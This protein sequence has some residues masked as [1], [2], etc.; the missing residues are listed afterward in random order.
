M[1]WD[2]SDPLG[3]MD[4]LNRMDTMD[5]IDA[6]DQMVI[7]DRMDF[8]RSEKYAQSTVSID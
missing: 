2:A 4:V 7:T 3:E 5:E 6:M 1:S 8:C